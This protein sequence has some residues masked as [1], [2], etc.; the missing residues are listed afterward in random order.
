MAAMACG[1]TPHQHKVVALAPLAWERAVFTGRESVAIGFVALPAQ[2]PIVANVRR[3]GR[4][5]VITLYAAPLHGMVVAMSVVGCVTVTAPE[6][7]NHRHPRDGTV[8]GLGRRRREQ[9]HSG[10]SDVKDVSLRHARCR[11]VPV[12]RDLPAPDIK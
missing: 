12:R 4:D 7:H 6:L 11:P 2:P 8:L 3:R 9:L 5:S 10:A 1:S